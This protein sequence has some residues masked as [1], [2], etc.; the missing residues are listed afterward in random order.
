MNGT[1][2]SIA[3]ILTAAGFGV[4]ASKI[5]ERIWARQD[6]RH[7]GNATVRAREI[8][9]SAAMRRELWDRVAVLEDQVKGLVAEVDKWKAL[10]YERE[11]DVIR[12]TA[13]VLQL[14]QRLSGG[15]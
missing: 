3:T 10:Y 11:Q 4:V 2:E 12:L 15:V 8:D 14:E 5:L 13:Q 7:G 1:F 9:D 6:S